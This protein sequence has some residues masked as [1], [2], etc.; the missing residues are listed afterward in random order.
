MARHYELDPD[1]TVVSGYSMGAIGTYR[2]MT[3]WPDL[4]ARGM[5]TV[6]FPDE[7]ARL[8][9]LRNTP[10]MA[11]AA[12]ADE[13]V[14]IAFTEEAVADL[15][16]LGLRFVADLFLAADHLT[17]AT[18]DEYSPVAAFLGEHR[19]DRNPSARDLRGRARQRLR[20]RLGGG[21]PRLLALGPAHSGRGGERDRDHRRAVRGLRRR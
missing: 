11:W 5:S 15:S 21:R 7:S 14:N 3:R 18:N 6:G 16:D 2:L 12:S 8:P 20:A 1:W 19:V 17:L 13:L 9:S 10:I 4:F